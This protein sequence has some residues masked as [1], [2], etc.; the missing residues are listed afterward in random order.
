MD[1]AAAVHQALHFSVTSRLGS[2]QFGTILI[3]KDAWLIDIFKVF[4]MGKELTTV[5]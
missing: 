3:G 1:Q 5:A 2:G 4:F